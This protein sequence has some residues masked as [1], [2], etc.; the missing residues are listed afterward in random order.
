MEKQPTAL[1]TRP[2]LTWDI[3]PFVQAFSVLSP[4]H[5]TINGLVQPLP[6]SEL[7]AYARM[8]GVDDIEEF[9]VVMQAADRTYLEYMRRPK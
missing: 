7:E 3:A 1:A 6:L 5:L 4:S 9:I 8:F 2:E